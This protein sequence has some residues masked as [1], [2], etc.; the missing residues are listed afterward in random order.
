MKKILI[1]F[2]I[3]FMA[4]SNVGAQQVKHTIERGETL[5]SIARHYNVTVDAIKK[6]NPEIGDMFFT[7]MII[8]IPSKAPAQT[9]IMS[10][11][12]DTNLTSQQ[13]SSEEQRPI[14]AT[15]SSTDN[16]P[17]YAI[18]RGDRFV[19]MDIAY[20][21]ESF[22]N[23]DSEMSFSSS[24][25]MAYE[26]GGGYY[27]VN[28]LFIEGAIGLTYGRFTDTPKPGYN[29]GYKKREQTSYGIQIPIH[30]GGS[31][32]IGNSCKLNLYTGPA[33][34]FPLSTKVKIDG[35]KQNDKTD[36]KISVAWVLGANLNLGGFKLG[37]NL[38]Y[39]LAE[40]IQN[41]GPGVSFYLGCEM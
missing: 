31:L 23:K 12:T 40:K 8:V 37:V 27:L 19:F 41:Q 24:V 36:I 5:E 39:P 29:N 9:S 38:G 22:K 32:P 2:I 13:Q 28:N 15:T 34:G 11:V 7:G 25:N 18:R 17:D 1:L 30:I 20:T 4:V 6:A 3:L 35:E 14:P 33:C 16:K 21:L 26:I 10:N